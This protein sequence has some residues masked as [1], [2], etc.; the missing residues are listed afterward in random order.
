MKSI[1]LCRK[2]YLLRLV[3]LRACLTSPLDLIIANLCPGLRTFYKLSNGRL[4]RSRSWEPIA[5]TVSVSSS[6]LWRISRKSANRMRFRFV[7]WLLKLK[8]QE[9]SKTPIHR[10][11]HA[12]IVFHNFV[13]CLRMI[14]NSF[15]C[16]LSQHWLQMRKKILILRFKMLMSWQM[17]REEQELIMERRRVTKYNQ[18][19]S[20]SEAWKVPSK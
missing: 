5:L 15:W 16:K 9:P 10:F 4:V 12:P 17:L 2:R 1:S 3:A 19:K 18:C 13:L 14:S 6:H 20:K 8:Y 7:S 11:R